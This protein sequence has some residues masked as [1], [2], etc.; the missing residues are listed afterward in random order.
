MFYLA[1]KQMLAKKKQ[2]FLIFLGIGFGT[3]IYIIVA[4]LQ[5]GMREFFIEQLLNNSAH[6]LISG[7]EKYIEQDQIQPRFYNDNEI[8]K[9]IVPPSGKRDEIRLK[10]PQGW[11]DF[12]EKN[13]YVLSYSPRYVI[14]AIA[15]QSKFKA[16]IN[17]LGII[18][19]KHIRVTDLENY[20]TSGSI[21]D[22]KGG[23]NTIV[24]SEKLLKKLGAKVSS[25]VLISTG[26]DTPLPFKVVGSILMGNEQTDETLAI[27][28]IVD[29]QKLDH[30]PGE[31]TDISVSLVDIDYAEPLAEQWRRM[32]TDKVQSWQEVNTHF[33]EMIMIQDLFRYLI[34]ATVLI[35]SG[36]GIYNVLSIM[37]SQKQKEIAILRSIGYSSERIL[38]LFFAQGIILGLAGGFLGLLLGFVVC[39]LVGSI[40]LTMQI[41]KSNHLWIS[42][43]PFIYIVGFFAAF[44]S[45]IIA[46]LIPSYKAS[47]LTPLE[48][49]RENS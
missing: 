10:N 34:T 8:V 18:P 39:Q 23:T 7:E 17:L 40:N 14:Q 32:S 1:I 27:S 16:S 21:L 11:Y 45:S 30:S 43:D 26:T 24:M 33:M 37:I 2:T 47:R 35:V 38:E 25:T 6:I 48:I 46:G 13:P 44:C 49:I 31:I 28:H 22:I 9:W 3:M 4:G 5:L 41:G 29:V 12:L 20:M 15:T 42:Y 19:Q 36:F